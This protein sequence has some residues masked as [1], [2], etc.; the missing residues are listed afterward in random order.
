V[1]A[2]ARAARG[3]VVGDLLEDVDLPAEAGEQVGGEEAPEGA[4]DDQRFQPF[5]SRKW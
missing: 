2:D 3:E 1:R 4:A 5:R